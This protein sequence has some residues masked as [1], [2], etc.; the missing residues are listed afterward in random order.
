MRVD[1]MSILL[2]NE[3]GVLS[4]ILK[5]LC[6]KSINIIGLTINENANFGELRLIVDSTE[7]AK[8]ILDEM[9]LTYNIVRIIV[10]RLNNEPGELLNISDL[11]TR[12]DINIDY[13][14]SLTSTADS[15]YVAIKT[16]NMEETA[17]LLHDSDMELVDIDHFLK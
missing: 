6:R 8:E 7:S 12:N 17:T 9:S 4:A 2:R 16:W 10:V 3:P 15:S 13:I 5:E 1:Q 14:Y 11:L